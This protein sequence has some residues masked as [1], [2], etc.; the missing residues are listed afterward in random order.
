MRPFHA[1]VTSVTLCSLAAGQTSL[2]AHYRLDETSG[3]VA[4]D[5]SGNGN[6]GTYT[7]VGVTLGVPGVA[8]SSTAV[9][10]DGADG[11]VAIPSSPSLDALTSD[12]TVASWVNLDLDA[13]MRIFG[14]QRLGGIGG[15][16]SFGPLGAGAMRF[17]T[18]GLQDYNQASSVAT[19]TWHHMALVFDASFQAHF[20]LDGALQGTVPGS[21][22]ANAPNTGW[23]IAV[24]DLT[25]IPE[26]F[27]GQIDDVQVYSGS[28]SASDIQFLFE[29][30]GQT[31]AG[32]GTSYCV[33]T[34]NSTGVAATI[35]ASGTG[36]IAAN[37]L[38]LRVEG[39]AQQ[40]GIFIASRSPVQIPFFNGF[41]CVSPT[42]L[43]RFLTVSSPT[44]G[45]TTEA[46]DIPNAT[47]GG[48]N[49]SAGSSTYFQRWFRDPAAG[50]GSANFSDGLDVLYL[51]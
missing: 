11:H 49:V 7:G 13:L 51:P 28:A 45:V 35:S 19:G 26:W 37:D 12:F 10:F 2:T 18:L 3:T 6:D 39:Q 20:Y 27:D 8:A 14:N 43:Q 17:T 24:L 9:D 40:P 42:G 1:L 38:I 32:V 16:W 5:S 36:S 29:N 33:S 23:F 25:G 44:N 30:P 41:L 46:V 15:S 31:L 50:G 21:A 34:T 48:L 47:P 4:A 22:P